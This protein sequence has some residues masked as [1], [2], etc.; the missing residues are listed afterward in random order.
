M[1]FCFY[2]KKR[3][4]DIYT[5]H[6]LLSPLRQSDS[7]I[8]E[9]IQQ[10][11]KRQELTLSLIASENYASTA[12]LSA[13]GSVLTNKYAEGYPHKRYYQ[14]CAC[15]DLVESLAIE[16]AKKLFGAKFANVQSHSGAQANEAAY[17][18]LAEPGDTILGMALSSGGHLTHGA[19]V[20][21]SGKVYHSIAYNVK[22]SDGLI[23]YDEAEEL[24]IQ[25][26]P[27][28]IITGCSA[29]SREIDWQ[30]FRQIAD[31]VNA[32]LL[33]DIAHLAGLIA[34]GVYP[35]PVGIVDVITT[36]TH[37]TLRGPR[38]GMILTNDEALAKKINSAVFP[39]TQ[40]GPLMHVIAAKAVAFKEALQPEFKHYQQQV[41]RNAKAM[42]KAMIDRGYKVVSNGTD[43]HCFLVD[44]S[45]KDLTGKTAAIALEEANIVLN[46]NTIPGETRSPFITS[47]IRIGTP[48]I[49]TRG[50][51]E[52]SS[53]QLAHWICDIL[54]D[55]TN[56]KVIGQV[57]TKVLQLVKQFSAYNT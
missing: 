5:M 52:E 28:L 36:T 29:Y 17:A 21:F 1:V 27:K 39:G 18:A 25:H 38:G 16:R 30:R 12:V 13:Q 44:F 19:A 55:T 9:L 14:G 11:K 26:K 22:S 57:K 40:G 35:S 42:A 7:D 10:E 43:S 54:D 20:N 49:T 2:Y 34:A 33:A 47:G 15:V 8:D 51:N 48:A 41:I 53:I 56:A 4:R 50:L 31:K 46:K 45:N 6:N 32:F 3:N 37:K 24:A 23:D